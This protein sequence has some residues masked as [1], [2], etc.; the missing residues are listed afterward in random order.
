MLKRIHRRWR[1]KKKKRNP[2]LIIIII[3]F[4]GYLALYY[5]FLNGY[6]EY[7]EYNKMIITEEAM[8]EFENDIK[9]GKDISINNYISTDY[10]DYSNN[11]SNLGLKTGK[12]LENTVNKGLGGIFKV[13]GKLFTN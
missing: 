1:M 12:F 2:V 3:L 11:I 6:Y 5:A 10:K 9:E 13:V 8:K 4:G 7:K